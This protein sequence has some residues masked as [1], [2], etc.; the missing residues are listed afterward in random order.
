AVNCAA[1][2]EDLLESELFGHERGAFTGAEARRIGRFE[3]AHGGTIFLDEIGD[4]SPSTQVKLLR[5]LQERCLQR[6]G[7][8]ETINVDVRIIA[9]THCHLEMAMREKRFREDL[10][11]RLS[12]AVIGVPPLRDRAEDIPELTRYFLRK[13]G[14][15]F[16]A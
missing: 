10:F 2:P 3:Q 13:H 1:I 11:Y 14:P 16:G 6:V 7:G 8:K 15:D 5:V 12:V 9:A 4:L